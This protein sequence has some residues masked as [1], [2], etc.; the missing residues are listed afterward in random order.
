MAEGRTLADFAREV[1]DLPLTEEQ[2]L[3]VEIIRETTKMETEKSWANDGDT[4]LR[5]RPLGPIAATPY[6]SEDLGERRPDLNRLT[7]TVSATVA[8]QAELRLLIERLVQVMIVA[9]DDGA[10]GATRTYAVLRPLQVKMRKA[11]PDAPAELQMTYHGAKTALRELATYLDRND[12]PALEELRVQL[13]MAMR[14]RDRRAHESLRRSA[15][16]IRQSRG[17]G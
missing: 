17:L 12:A 15:Q 4:A 9:N 1:F 11:A 7:V 8:L 13:Q 10:D 14:E 16:S 5:H 3:I 6:A 2:E